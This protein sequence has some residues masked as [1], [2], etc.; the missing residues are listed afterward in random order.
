M[1]VALGYKGNEGQTFLL[2]FFAMLEDIPDCY[3]AFC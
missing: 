1:E 2:F 3:K